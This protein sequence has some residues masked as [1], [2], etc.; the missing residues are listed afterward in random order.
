[1]DLRRDVFPLLTRV[2]GSGDRLEE[3]CRGHSRVPVVR[4]VGSRA[5]DPGRVSQEPGPRLTQ[6]TF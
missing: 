6:H 5:A 1:M 3:P 2:G 4:V